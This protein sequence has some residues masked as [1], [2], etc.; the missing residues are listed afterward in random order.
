LAP[1][2]GSLGF[3]V[4]DALQG[5]SRSVS[6]G[7]AVRRIRQALV[8]AQLAM[9]LTLL[10]GAGLLAKSF[11]QLRNTDPG[12][13][14]ENVLTARVNLAGPGYATVGRQKEF[15]AD[16][17]QRIG[18]LPG[19][20][21]AG[22]GGIPPGLAGNYGLAV[23]QGQPEP[24]SGQER[25]AAQV[26]VSPDY[27]HVLNVPLLEGR[28]LS[29][30]DSNGAPLVVVTN[31]AFA[32]KY[33]PGQ[34]ALGHRVS[35]IQVDP[36]EPG[37]AEIVGVVGNMRDRGLDQDV[38]PAIYRPYLQEPLPLLARANL[39]LRASRDPVAILPTI[40][41]LVA[42]MDRDQPVY[43]ART[44]E[45]RLADSLGSR[46]FNAALTGAFALIAAFLACIGV[47]GVMSYLV[48]MKVAK[49]QPIH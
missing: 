36:Q 5:E 6:S 7:T 19:V 40:E 47:Y 42:A 30:A 16:L 11:Y 33:F 49:W 2:L 13:R 3:G 23:I 8:I 25:F 39:L 15:I 46:R 9:S 1:S 44:M 21:A 26:D 28:P 35:T 18:K 34:S 12:Y 22:I 20:E 41:K 27:F 31:E 14:P 45:R 48:K 37:W 4:R 24:A 38:T 10:I 29:S 17:L 32:R 43:D